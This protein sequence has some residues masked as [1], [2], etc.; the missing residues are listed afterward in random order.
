MPFSRFFSHYAGQIYKVSGSIP[1]NLDQAVLQELF[2]RVVGEMLQRE[3]FSILC[4]ALSCCAFG[5]VIFSEGGDGLELDHDDLLV[6]VLRFYGIETSREELM[7]FAQ[8]FWAQS[9][10]L[11]L[12]H[13]W[14][15]P[16]ASQFPYRIFEA[17]SQAI[18]HPPEKCKEMM[19]ILINEWRRQAKQIMGKYGY[20]AP[21]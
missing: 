1:E 15:P 19:D 11:K 8:N 9:M 21:W 3:Y 17:V 13:G 10:D 14:Q 16:D 12:K 6:E 20:E 2:S 18:S 5:F 7:R 4:N